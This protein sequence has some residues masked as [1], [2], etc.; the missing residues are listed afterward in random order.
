MIFTV[1][2]FQ[3]PIHVLILDT[4]VKRRQVLHC[5]YIYS[6]RRRMCSA[7]TF[8]EN[9]FHR[10]L[11]T[12]GPKPL[13]QPILAPLANSERGKHNR[14]YNMSTSCVCMCGCDAIP[15]Q[16]IK[17]VSQVCC[18]FMAPVFPAQRS[19]APSFASP[20]TPPMLADLVLV[21]VS[22]RSSSFQ[23]SLMRNPS[24]RAQQDS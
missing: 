17:S 21:V 12:T 9:L 7:H 19:C 18:P 14:K 1:L 13:S 8:G 2:P 6:L 24:R 4:R 23:L 3:S 20:R 22:N 16:S 11:V 10:I 5:I 15:S